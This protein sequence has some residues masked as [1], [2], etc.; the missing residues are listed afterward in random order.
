MQ[1]DPMPKEQ[2][3]KIRLDDADRARLDALAAHY[4]IPVAAV[5]RMLVKRDADALGLQVKPTKRAKGK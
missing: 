3:Y 5:L 2:A 4:A 1:A